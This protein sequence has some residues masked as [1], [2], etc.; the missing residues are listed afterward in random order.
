MQTSYRRRAQAAVR[1]EMYDIKGRTAQLYPIQAVHTERAT[2]ISF[3]NTTVSGKDFTSVLAY[4]H[5]TGD[6]IMVT[7]VLCVLL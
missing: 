6:V 1:A 3:H 2:A 4:Q 7:V 5:H